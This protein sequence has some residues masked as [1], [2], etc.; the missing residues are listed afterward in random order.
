[1]KYSQIYFLP[2]PCAE[3]LS[4]IRLTSEHVREAVGNILADYFKCSYLL[5]IYSLS[6]NDAKVRVRSKRLLELAR[7]TKDCSLILC[8]FS[9]FDSLFIGQSERRYLRCSPLLLSSSAF[10]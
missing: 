8:V 2:F 7:I 1:L 3:R 9:S 10:F 4:N 6:K 5:F